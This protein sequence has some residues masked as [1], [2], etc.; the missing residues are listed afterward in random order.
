MRLSNITLYLE[1]REDDDWK[2]CAMKAQPT[3]QDLY[4][5]RMA[6]FGLMEA[7]NPST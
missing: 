2:L 6:F 3:K 4:N 1:C 5:L 7:P